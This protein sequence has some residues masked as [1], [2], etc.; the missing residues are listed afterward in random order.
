ML[1]AVRLLLGWLALL[2]PVSGPTGGSRNVGD[3]QNPPGAAGR[4]NPGDDAPPAGAGPRRELRPQS[5]TSRALA[6]I[7]PL[8]AIVATLTVVGLLALRLLQ[9]ERLPETLAQGDL[10]LGAF[11]ITM[12][13]WAVLALWRVPQWQ[14][15]RWA[16]LAGSTPRER[17]DMENASRATLGQ[18]LSGVA[19]VSGLIFAWQQLG[20]TYRTVQLTEQRA[21]TDRFASA[22]AQLA[23]GDLSVRMGGVY[24]LEQI[25][26]ESDREYL[27]VMQ[28]LAAFIRERRQVVPSPIGAAATPVALDYDAIV[29]GIEEADNAEDRARLMGALIRYAPPDD[30]RAAVLAIA[31]R[32]P[33]QVR[34][35]D[36]AG[37]ECL[38]LSFVRLPAM[39]VPPGAT[40]AGTCIPFGDFFGAELTGVDFSNSLLADASFRGTL[41]EKARFVDSNLDNAVFVDADAS[42]AR[43]DGAN[44]TD[45]DLS[46]A[47]L[48]GAGFQRAVLAGAKFDD[49]VLRGSDLSEA[50]A[51]RGSF[52]GADL[53]GANLTGTNLSGADLSRAV[54]LTDEQLAAAIVDEATRLPG[55]ASLLPAT[56][57]P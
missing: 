14:A 21:I 19:V 28:V 34:L 27:P 16:S 10:L 42:G 57:A 45:A 13:L 39:F 47:I 55:P 23:S 1:L 15:D 56:A 4:G 18:I 32:T 48:D 37:I 46:A 12:L 22:V 53:T 5:P 26:R 7:G 35:E 2:L 20:S 3:G 30:V 54:G 6:L 8:V 52:A 36:G 50:D 25:A 40:F 41:I 9:P 24:A 38:D 31:S 51:S 29:A 11:L 43:F 17:F 44:L 33:V 49:A